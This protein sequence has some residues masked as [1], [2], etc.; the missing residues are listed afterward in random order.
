[1]DARSFEIALATWHRIRLSPRLAGAIAATAG[2]YAEVMAPVVAR[3]DF[4]DEP[5]HFVRVRDD[6]AMRRVL[7]P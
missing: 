4:D 2:R 1:M 5:A 7:R 3:L 6:A